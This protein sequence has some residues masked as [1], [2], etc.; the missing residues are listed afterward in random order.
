MHPPG[1]PELRLRLVHGILRLLDYRPEDEAR[2]AGSVA[3]TGGDGETRELAVAERLLL[4]RLGWE[5]EGLL[6]DVRERHGPPGS[7][8][9]VVPWGLAARQ[10]PGAWWLHD[11]HSHEGRRWRAAATRRFW[12]RCGRAGDAPGASRAR[13]GRADSDSVEHPNTPAA[14]PRATQY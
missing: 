13:G 12:E 9:R 4:R 7:S 11:L 8:T 10:S 3:A 2:A 1:R 6:C 5:G 14:T